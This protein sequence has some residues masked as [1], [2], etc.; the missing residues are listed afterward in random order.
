MIP[1]SQQKL[2]IA[3]ESECKSNKWQLFFEVNVDPLMQMVA[4]PLPISLLVQQY[5]ELCSWYDNP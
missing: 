5:N 2:V 4:F 3:A 1:D